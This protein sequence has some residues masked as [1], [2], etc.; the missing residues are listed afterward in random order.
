MGSVSLFLACSLIVVLGCGRKLEEK[1]M[2][3]VIESETGGRARVDLSDE[4]VSIKTER[5]DLTI[6]SGKS[7]K[8]PSDF[9]ADVHIYKGATV[10][11]VAQMGDGSSITFGCEDAPSKVA[12]TYRDEMTGKGWVVGTSMDMGDQQMM[13]FTKEK[14]VVTVT[15]GES[16]GSTVIALILAQQ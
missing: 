9:P 1:A 10:T 14:R 13:M 15:V 8:L 2:E 3:N 4:R 5:G 12:D 16:E 7:A 11:A 6:T